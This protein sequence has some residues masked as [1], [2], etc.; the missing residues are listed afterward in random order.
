MNLLK[1]SP[2]I[3][4]IYK[5]QLFA[6]ISTLSIATIFGK[7]IGLFNLSYIARTFGPENY[8][9]IG[10]ATSL[11]AYAGII[12]SPGL[13][14]WGT[15]T[16]AQNKNR[17]G[18]TVISINFIQIFLAIIGFGILAG[19]SYF[20]STDAKQATIIT[21]CA[22]Q[23]FQ[24]AFSIDWAFNGLEHSRI[25]AILNVFSLLVIGICLVLFIKSSEDISLYLVIIFLVNSFFIIFGYFIFFIKF[26][27]HLTTPNISEVRKAFLDSL[28]L[29]LTTALVV[30]LHYSNNLIVKYFLGS[31]ALGEFL[32]DYRLLEL[33]STVPGLLS[34]VF[35]PRIARQV[36]TAPAI[37]KEEAKY[38][39]R[40]NMI[41]AFLIA[42]LI[43][44]ES[45]AIIQ[46]VFG[47]QF[48]NSVPLLRLMSFAIIFNFAICGYTNALISFGGDKVML[49]VVIVSAVVSIVGGFILVPMMGI[50][51]ATIVICL[52]DFS[53]WL[54]SVPA[55]KKTIGSM[56]I[57]W[58]LMPAGAFIFISIISIGFKT[59]NIPVWP[60]LIIEGLVAIA[61]FLFFLKELLRQKFSSKP[62]Q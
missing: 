26:N 18:E 15:R 28:P 46:I 58:W 55:Y 3:S 27:Y 4:K 61:V 2:S 56:N 41:L 45:N 48:L 39:G 62:A 36:I 22:L 21:L 30:I 31:N 23:L 25:P 60:R 38:F 5:T 20:F 8:G 53:G 40:I 6:N 12:L 19:Y 1:I 16:I 37:A 33:I 9:L 43:F 54:I 11:V 49:M 52:I 59:L 24:I 42:A 32:A 47:K 50:L 10:Y 51:G 34:V 57:K 14:T 13:L 44:S 29:N 17:V 7:L 35:L